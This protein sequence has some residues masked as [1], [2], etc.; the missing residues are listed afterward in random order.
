MPDLICPID[1]LPLFPQEHCLKC[2]QGHSFDRAK[3]GYF[4]LLPVQHKRSK[5][6]G[7]NKE[8]VNARRT[9][10]NN[11]YYQA[12]SQT[13][14][15]TILAKHL[16]HSNILDAGCGEGYYLN[17]LLTQA[18][19]QNINLQACGLDISKFAIQ[20]AA[21]SN[22]TATWLVASNKQ[23]PFPEHYFDTIFCAFGFPVYQ[24]FANK[25]K[26]NG[27]L[28]LLEVG[29]HHQIELRQ[30]L[31]PSVKA[32]SAIDL[33]PAFD[34]GFTLNDQQNIRF[35]L[36]LKQA[37]LQQLL[38]MTPHLYRAPKQGLENVQQ[39]ESLTVTIDVILYQLTLSDTPATTCNQ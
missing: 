12:I 19:Q 11:G 9:F 17:Q 37:E 7:D 15:Q 10:L 14:N 35:E 23:L 30:H 5:A 13:L 20:A 39:L 28:L 2:E 31:Y 4:N 18:Q 25:L 26:N 3:Q 24:E 22:K 21:K 1:K 33:Q 29:E 8:M 34:C 38:A 16:N 36:T 32:Y 27:Q 6:P